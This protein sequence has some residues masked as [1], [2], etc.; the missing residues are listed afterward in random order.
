V[1]PRL[2]GKDGFVGLWT[3]SGCEKRFLS[4][5]AGFEGKCRKQGSN[6]KKALEEKPKRWTHGLALPA[7][8]GPHL[9]R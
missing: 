2:D 7:V 4:L 1:E 8:E 6:E 3:G 9:I 5:G